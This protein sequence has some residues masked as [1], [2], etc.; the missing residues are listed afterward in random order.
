MANSVLVCTTLFALLIAS[1]ATTNARSPGD[2]AGELQR[3]GRL[4]GLQECEGSLNAFGAARLE[5]LAEQ[6][7]HSGTGVAV[8][9]ARSNSVLLQLDFAAM[10]DGKP[11]YLGVDRGTSNPISESQLERVLEV[12][13]TVQSSSQDSMSPL[14]PVCDYVLVFDHGRVKVAAGRFQSSRDE[15]ANNASPLVVLSRL[16]VELYPPE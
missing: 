13:R 2:L 6:S 9:Y 16:M 7:R 11:M 15:G 10:V 12:A 14:H 3:E 1:C 5:S 8:L 4:M